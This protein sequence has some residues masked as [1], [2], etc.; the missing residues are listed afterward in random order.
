IED[1]F[2]RHAFVDERNRTR[3]NESKIRAMRAPN[4]RT[5]LLASS[6][7]IHVQ[8]AKTTSTTTFNT[9]VPSDAQFF[10]Q[11]FRCRSSLG[12][13]IHLQSSSYRYCP[14]GDVMLL[15]LSH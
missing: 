13:K 3:T 5:H 15:C 12:R 6:L 1:L 7:Q 9:Q 10:Q 11:R 8:C 2:Q 14:S 4:S